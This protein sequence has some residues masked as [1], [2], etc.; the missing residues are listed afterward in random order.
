MK[1]NENFFYQKYLIKLFIQ[2]V[3]SLAP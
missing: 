1:L 2:P 3:S